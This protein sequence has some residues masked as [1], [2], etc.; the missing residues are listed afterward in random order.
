[1]AWT[2]RIAK[3]AEKELRKIPAKD[4]ERILAALRAIEADPFS[5]DVAR[6][7]NQPAGWRLRVGNYRVFLD[8]YPDQSVVDILRVKRR[9]STTY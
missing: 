1:M 4:R 8:L 7:I 6:L 2:L 3:R 5:G 9:T